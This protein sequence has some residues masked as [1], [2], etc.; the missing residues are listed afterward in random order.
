MQLPGLSYYHA[1]SLC[2]QEYVSS[3]LAL[4]C[5]SVVHSQWTQTTLQ[6]ILQ[7][8]Q[9]KLHFLHDIIITWA[10]LS[11]ACVLFRARE[12]YGWLA[13]LLQSSFGCVNLP[14]SKSW[15]TRK[16]RVPPAWFAQLKWGKLRDQWQNV[17]VI[18][19][20]RTKLN[21]KCIYVVNKKNNNVASPYF[22]GTKK[23]NAQVPTSQ[24]QKSAMRKSLLR[25]PCRALGRGQGVSWVR[26]R[27]L[28]NQLQKYDTWSM[29][30]S[31]KMLLFAESAYRRLA[32]SFWCPSPHRKPTKN[33]FHFFTMN[34]YVSLRWM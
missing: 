29:Q 3:V 5:T 20:V 10:P 15:V 26:T 13:R 33:I 6:C 14:S 22:S 34:T 30:V 11:P 21:S 27:E 4:K 12:E 18:R 28:Q 24:G 1:R 8:M 23:R 7:R 31:C 2:T 16:S 32:I 19:C 17:T 9:R 25:P